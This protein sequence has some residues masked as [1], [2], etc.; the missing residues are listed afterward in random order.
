MQEKKPRTGPS[1]ADRFWSIFLFT[2]NGKVKNPL[3]IY[4]FSLSFVLLAV[5]GAAY[6]FLIDPVHHLFSGAPAWLT[7]L[8]ESLIPALAGSALLL[9]LQKATGNRV[10]IPAAYVWLLLY[11]TVVIAWMLL[12]VP[13]GEDRAFFLDLFA[14]V[15][16]APLILGGIPSWLLYRKQAGSRHQGPPDGRAKL[17]TD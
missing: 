6:W 7:G 14:R 5:Y 11:A 1:R 10:Y 15:I 17:A 3:I 2:K 4:S 8:A 12:T 16:P 13:S 9:L